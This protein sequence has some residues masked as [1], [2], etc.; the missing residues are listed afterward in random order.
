VDL[1]NLRPDGTFGDPEDEAAGD[2]E[3]VEGATSG[4][5]AFEGDTFFGEDG[6]DA[7][8][9]VATDADAERSEQQQA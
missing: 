6:G 8:S 7:D 9:D 1:K 4:G 5:L 3:S 2:D